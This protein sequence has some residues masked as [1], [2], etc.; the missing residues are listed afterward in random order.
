MTSNT[1]RNKNRNRNTNKNRYTIDDV[2]SIKHSGEKFKYRSNF[3]Y[4]YL[5]YN[6][7]R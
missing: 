2:K 4:V 3:K 5:Q 6:I 1:N 7:S